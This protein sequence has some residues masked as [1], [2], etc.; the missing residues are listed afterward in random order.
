MPSYDVPTAAF[1]AG[2]SAKWVDNITSHHEI[3]GVERRKRGVLR[4]FS[5][6]A[7]ILLRIVRTLADDLEI[8][9]WRAVEIA[10]GILKGGTGQ[11]TLDGGTTVLVDLDAITRQVRQRLLEAAESVPRI[12]RGRPPASTTPG[13]R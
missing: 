5:F 8:P 4:E 7:L 12:R 2:A 11:V 13:G 1:V 9:A 10:P 6:D 3:P